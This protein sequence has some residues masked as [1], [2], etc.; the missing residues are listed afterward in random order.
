MIVGKVLTAVT[1]RISIFFD[2]KL[3][4]LE[5]LL[6]DNPLPLFPYYELHTRLPSCDREF[7]LVKSR[8][9]INS[10]YLQQLTVVISNFLVEVSD[11]TK[12]KTK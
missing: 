4:V 1:K 11:E 12:K 3:L 7:K 6:Y 9:K 10:E 8:F 2:V 5:I